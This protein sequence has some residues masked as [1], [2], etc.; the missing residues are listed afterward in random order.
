MLGLVFNLAV[1]RRNKGVMDAAAG[2]RKKRI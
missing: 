1:H 2:I